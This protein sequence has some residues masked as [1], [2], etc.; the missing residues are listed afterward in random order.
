MFIQAMKKNTFFKRHQKTI[1]I[2]F[3]IL[4]TAAA[5]GTWFLLKNRNDSN[6]TSTKSSADS[7]ESINYSPGTDQDQKDADQRKQEIADQQNQNPEPT[8]GKKSVTPVI[9]DASQYGNE[10]EVRAYVP[11]IIED[12]GTC[13]VTFTKGSLS[14]TKQSTGEKDATTTRCTNITIPRSE[15]KDYGKWNVSLSYS[16]S[17]TQ[18]TA[19]ARTIEVQ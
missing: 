10:V 5:G 9:V 16:S 17:T 19:S 18:G 11:G 13:T 1:L 8:T 4:V 3:V 14:V 15:F 12:G 6:N 7:K 2:T